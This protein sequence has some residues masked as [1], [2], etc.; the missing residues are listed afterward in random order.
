[1]ETD[2]LEF[3]TVTQWW[4]QIMKI[5]NVFIINSNICLEDL[6]MTKYSS[7]NLCN[8]LNWN[9]SKRL[10]SQH[11]LRIAYF[12]PNHIS[13]TCDAVPSL[14]HVTSWHHDA[15][16]PCLMTQHVTLGGGNMSRR[17]IGGRGRR[18]TSSPMSPMMERG[19]GDTLVITSC[20]EFNAS[21][22]KCYEKCCFWDNQMRNSV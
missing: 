16:W 7:E 14:G 12:D 8:T 22:L 3:E 10:I 17:H 20:G 19:G 1:M 6:K 15:T 13:D 9:L 2:I 11:I 21:T 5:E 4:F 18:L